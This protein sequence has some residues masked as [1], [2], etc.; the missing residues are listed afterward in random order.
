LFDV[1][2]AFGVHKL[3]T[4]VTS[5]ECCEFAFFDALGAEAIAVRPDDFDVS[6]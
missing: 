5:I 4:I 3:I 6:H 1:F 2:A